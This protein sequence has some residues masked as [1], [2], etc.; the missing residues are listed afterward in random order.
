MSVNL[1]KMQQ[2]KLDGIIAAQKY[3]D[4]DIV[5]GNEITPDNIDDYYQ[6]MYK[7][8][9][10]SIYKI[11][12][13][14]ID[15]RLAAASCL[16]HQLILDIRN[17]LDIHEKMA[18]VELEVYPERYRQIAIELGMPDHEY[19]GKGKK[20]P[21]LKKRRNVIKSGLVFL[22]IYRGG[23]ST[24]ANVLGVP[25]DVAAVL[26]GKLFEHYPGIKRWHDDIQHF[27]SL[28]KCLRS[29]TGALLEGPLGYGEMVNYGI[30]H[31][32]RYTVGKM[33]KRLSVDLQLNVFNEVHD[34][35]NF[36][37]DTA[38][39]S[40]V[41]PKIA[42]VFCTPQDD[43]AKVLP[44]ACE[45]ERSVLTKTGV[46]LGTMESIAE[47]SSK[48]F[49]WVETPIEEFEIFYKRQFQKVIRKPIIF[50]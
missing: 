21:I 26:L 46:G 9:K 17:D 40:I 33:M 25:V 29:I 14:Q 12:S 13:G 15:F 16:D 49:G 22:G 18:L 10:R 50:I 44:L 34:E 19:N 41:L 38:D 7:N 28:N 39:E 31:A 42:E 20:D 32:T 2:I 35:H 47:Y 43:W 8:V 5:V 11:D 45:I 24:S 36:D 30:Q 27:Y 4:M 3:L 23:V 48:D 6:K 37:G 1:D